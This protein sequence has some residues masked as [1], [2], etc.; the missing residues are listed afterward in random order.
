MIIPNMAP[1]ENL[2]ATDFAIVA[3]STAP[4]STIISIM[5]K[6]STMH[7]TSLMADSKLRIV[8]LLSLSL[9]LDAKDITTMLL[10]PP[11]IV[12]NKIEYK[13]DTSGMTKKCMIKLVTTALDA[14]PTMARTIAVGL[15]EK[16]R[17]MFMAIP[18]SNSMKTRAKAAR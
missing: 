11:R 3:K 15:S 2:L 14:N 8:E 5:T 1:I 7:S 17:F 16:T 10:L 6:D 4:P 12:P 13:G 9:I 18:P